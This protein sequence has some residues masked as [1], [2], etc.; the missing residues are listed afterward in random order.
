MPAGGKNVDITWEFLK[1]LGGA[2][3][4]AFQ[5]RDVI[6]ANNTRVAVLGSHNRTGLSGFPEVLPS[7]AVVGIFHVGTVK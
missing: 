7:P 6:P 3:A 1:Y 2:E 5:A 4:Q